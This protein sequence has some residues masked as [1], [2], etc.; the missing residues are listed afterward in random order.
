MPSVR[1]VVCFLIAG[2]LAAAVAGVAGSALAAPVARAAPAA[3]EHGQRQQSARTVKAVASG[4]AVSI[5]SVSPQ[6]ADANSTIEVKGTI[7][8]DTG[9]PLNGVQ[10]ELY[11]SGSWFTAR[12]Q[13]DGPDGFSSGG[14]WTLNPVIGNAW[15]APSTLH[16]GVTMRWSASFS[17][18]SQGYTS[19]KVYPLEAAA[20]SSTGEVLDY[21]RTFLPYWPASGGGAFDKLDIAWIWPLIDKPHQ[22]ACSH[23]LT[24]ND[25]ASSFA[26]GGRLNGLLAAGLGKYASSIRLTWAVDPALLSDATVMTQR[27]GYK[28][29][30]DPACTGTTS[31]PP[32]QAAT[33]WLNELRTGTAGEPMFVTPYADPDVSAL[34]HAGLDEGLAQAYAVGDNRAQQALGRSFGPRTP[35]TAIAWPADGAADASVLTRLASDHL[36]TTVLNSGEMPALS[37]SAPDDAVTSVPTGIST[38]MRVLLADSQISTEL[39]SVTAAS[40]ASA[41]FNVEQDF[42]AETA[43]IVSEAP[44]SQ[45]SV[46]IAPPRRWDPS[47]D[48]A[49]ALLRLTHEPWLQPVSLASLASPK[50]DTTRRQPLPGSSVAPQELSKEYMGL[51]ATVR[52][53]ADLYKSMLYQPSDEVTSSLD[54]AV[55]ATESSAWRGRAS[56]GG[57]QALH[58]LSSYFHDREKQVQIISGNHETVV[59]AGASGATPVSV[60]NGLD[61]DVKVGV[62]ALVPPGSQLSIGNNFNSPIV[63]LRG[64]TRIVRMPVS[65]AALGTTLIHLQLVTTNGTPLGRPQSL[66]IES[67]RVGRV[68]LI[69]I[70][71]ALGVLV[72]ASL[73]RWVRRWWRDGISGADARSGGAG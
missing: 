7:T 26:A 35:G 44:N 2:V 40:P 37:I 65:S 14:Y 53:R 28:V 25:L 64:Q 45:R 6:F 3:A 73:A 47:E 4:V 22:G 66:S 42:L 15:P 68:L 29:G 19:Y 57:R 21:A 62:R 13:M 54:A 52:S 70:A 16:S 60:S 55:A 12:T 27:T 72:L 24:T 63:I 34:T 46:V 32:S 31:M 33:T 51:V 1:T 17:A 48:E 58:N 9:R 10:V 18:A 61:V 50:P 59:L 5:D 39:G 8:N 69:V 30:G 20:L 41:Q 38:T 36:G 23:D 43:M 67:T 56:Q 11:T 49:A 71:A